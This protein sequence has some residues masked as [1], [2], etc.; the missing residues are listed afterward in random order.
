MRGNPGPPVTVNYS[1][2]GGTAV[3]GANYTPVSGTLVFAQGETT[4][5]FTIPII[6]EPGITGRPDGWAVPEQSHRRCHA[7][8]PGQRDPDDPARPPRPNRPDGREYPIPSLIADGVI[9]KLV[10]TFDK[11]LNPTTA[12]NLVN[13]GYSVRTAG[14]DHIFGTADDLIIPIIRRRL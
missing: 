14:R 1:T 6:D 5:S 7:G 4:Q 8:F 3:P 10:V 13:Y 2:G 11:P 9:N 12:V